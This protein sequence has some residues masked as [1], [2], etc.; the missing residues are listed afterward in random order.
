MRIPEL[1]GVDEFLRW[2][3]QQD[4]R[5][6]FAAGTVTLFAGVTR[7][8]ELVVGNLLSALRRTLGAGRVS[9]SSLKLVTQHSSRYPDIFVGA[10]PRDRL[11]GSEARDPTLLIEVLSELTDATDRGPKAEEY[12][13]LETLQEYVLVDSRE[14]SVQTIRRSGKDWITQLPVLA[15]AVRFESVDVEI[16][17]DAIYAGTKL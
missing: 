1:T 7:R 17:F 14:R 10:H 15:G 13:T 6:E 5:Y 4:Q 12:R 2:E 16:T 8:H 11:E 9:G 3:E